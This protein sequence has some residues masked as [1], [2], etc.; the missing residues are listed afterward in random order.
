[1]A[2]RSRREGRRGKGMGIFL[3]IRA[4]SYYVGSKSASMRSTFIVTIF[5]SR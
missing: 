4:F 3:K 5:P 2:A 1:M